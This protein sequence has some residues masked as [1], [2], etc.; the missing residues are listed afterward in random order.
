MVLAWSRLWAQT[1]LLF[2][3]LSEFGVSRV[4]SGVITWPRRQACRKSKV[5]LSAESLMQGGLCSVRSCL[6][7]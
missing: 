2:L 5:I 4:N 1:L 3:I 6:W 7:S